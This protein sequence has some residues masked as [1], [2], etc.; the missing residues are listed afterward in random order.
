[1]CLSKLLLF[2]PI[3]FIPTAGLATDVAGQKGLTSTC[4]HLLVNVKMF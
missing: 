4:V 1:M 3:L 2:I